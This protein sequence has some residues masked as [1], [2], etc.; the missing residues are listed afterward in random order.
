M[1]RIML[2]KREWSARMMTNG[3]VARG[4]LI[5]LPAP[6][7]K[8][9]QA[10]WKPCHRQSSLRARADAHACSAPIS[11]ACPLQVAA[12][13]LA[14]RVTAEGRYL[15]WCHWIDPSEGSLWSSCPP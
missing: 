11:Q 14:A 13:A 7:P 8:S 2:G 12:P 15:F 3:R 1:E 10:T 4:L 6:T 5:A 9:P